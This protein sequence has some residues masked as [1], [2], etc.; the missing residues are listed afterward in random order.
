MEG[1]VN[2]AVA[3][4]R[5]VI[6][7]QDRI[8]ELEWRLERAE[9]YERKYHELLDQSLAHSQHMVAGVFQVGMELARLRDKE[10]S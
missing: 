3:F 1:S 2:S 5:D 6:Q 8:E 4:A 7:M 10:T 9:E